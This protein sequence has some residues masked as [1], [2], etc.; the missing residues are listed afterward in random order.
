MTSPSKDGSALS[1]SAIAYAERGWPVF[2]CKPGDKAPLTRNGFKAA[3]TDLDQIESWWDFWTDAN[4]G[5]ATGHAFDVLDVDG[6]A[7]VAALRAFWRRKNIAYQHD[8]PVSLTGKGW[9]FLFAPTGRGNGAALLGPDSKLDFRGIGGYIVAAPSLHPLGHHYEWDLRR[10]PD[11]PIPAP[12][13]WLNDLL[14]RDD[15]PVA[16]KAPPKKHIL[17]NSTYEQLVAEGILPKAQAPRGIVQRVERP[18]ILEVC[19]DQGI[20]LRKRTHYWVAAC[21]FHADSTPSMAVYPSNNTFHCYGCGAHGDSYD[22]RNG[23]H[24]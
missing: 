24:L 8:G 23:T 7:G 11:T 16:A 22:L 14:D 13:A 6:D 4:I 20:R 9:H 10:G 12:P 19:A 1:A 21:V 3:T 5:L 17:P 18:D 2:P 15:N